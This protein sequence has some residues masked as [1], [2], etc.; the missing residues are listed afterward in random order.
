V[1]VSLDDVGAKH[2]SAYG[3][4]RETTPHLDAV[5][6]EGLLFESA[7][8]QQTWTLTS[9]LTMMTGLDPRAHGASRTHSVPPSV[10]TLAELLW[11][12]GF[13]TAAF[14]GAVAWMRPRYGLGRGF[15]TYEMG[16][17]DARLDAPR[18]VRWL[19]QQARLEAEDPE[20]R[21]FLFVHF[22][23]A[24]SDAGTPLPYYL[25]DPGDFDPHLYVPEGRRWEHSGGTELLMRLVRE[26][27]SEED[28]AFATA[29]YDAGVRYVDEYGVGPI[30]AALDE[31][32]LAENTLLVLTADHGEEIF[33]HG[34]ALHGFPHQ[35]TARVPLVLR[36]PG[37][38]RGARTPHLAALVDLMPTLLSLLGLPVPEDVQGRDLGPL[39]HGG[40]PVNEAV[41]V[42]GGHGASRA[43]PS[44]VVAD[45]DGQR[46]SYLVAVEGRE[47]DLVPQ[48]PGELYDMA[49]D[50]G[51]QHDLAA[52]R[53]ELAARL[54]QMLVAR[55][56]EAEALSRRLGGARESIGLS[57][58]ERRHLRE[59]GYG[60]DGP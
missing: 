9:H 21:F 46:W 22:F 41:F 18:A 1:L 19:A 17:S 59:L 60:E 25:A 27:A 31:H 57:D 45:L 44:M 33:E 15:E 52:S 20:H 32:G 24:H 3:Y 56:G 40:G 53:P 10:S 34:S 16:A 12:H 30:V 36:G 43:Y 11:N 14:T 39:L 47:G 51:Q 37:I 26:G 54:E 48:R 8:V 38:P 5:A 4:A 55:L 58:E 28:R 6:R 2:V 29:Y 49:Q 13:A 23:D 7:Y 50:P 42:D 35:E